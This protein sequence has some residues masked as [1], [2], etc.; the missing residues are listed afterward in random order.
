ME[1]VG[2]TSPAVI[3]VH[4]QLLVL[5]VVVCAE[6]DDVVMSNPANQLHL[7]LKVTAAGV[8][9]LEPLDDDR[10]GVLQ[11]GPVRRPEGALAKDLGGGAEQVLQV[12]RQRRALEED[13]PVAVPGLAND[14]L[15]LGRLPP[16][17]IPAAL[18]DN[19]AVAPC[20]VIT[21]VPVAEGEEQH[22]GEGEHEDAAAD[23][24]GEDGR[25]A[26]PDPPRAGLGMSGDLRLV[27]ALVACYPAGWRRRYGEEYQIVR[28][29][30][31]I[32]RHPGM[33]FDS[34]RGAV[35]AHGGA[36]MTDPSPTTVLVWAA[37]LFT[38]AGIFGLGFSG[39]ITAYVLAIREHFPASEASWRIPTLLLFSGMGMASGGWLAGLMYDHFGYYAP[40]FAAGIGANLL[41]LLE[42][43]ALVARPR[44]P[45][46]Y[47]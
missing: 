29:S 3:I 33:V 20:L 24:N 7:L 19:H 45:A 27:R 11:H 10:G 35:R 9:L 1:H 4:K 30:S 37:G 15:G 40:A 6:L 23:G 16:L 21:A 25:L 5:G 38:V 44:S 12:E 26:E 41:N 18:P 43:R 34:L 17:L 22:R 47:I 39:I 13:H 28:A 8:H 32:H 42:I 14:G 36:L 31:G 46:A 2:Y